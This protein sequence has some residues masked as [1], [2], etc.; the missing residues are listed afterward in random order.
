MAS[1]TILMKLHGRRAPGVPRWAAWTAYTITLVALPSCVWR[2]AAV[3]FNAP[4]LEHDAKTPA[5]PE[6]F[7]GEWWYIIGLS[8]VSEMLAFLAVGLV[9]Q[10]GEVWPRWI[11]GL[12]GRRVPVLAAVIPAGLGSLGLL[13]FPYA[14]VMSAL[15]LKITG[16]PHA[17]VAHGWQVVAFWVAYVPLAAWGPL[18]GI[19][20]VHYYR[21]RR[22]VRPPTAVAAPTPSCRRRVP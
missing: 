2:I 6:T 9:A 17:M 1:R 20:T 15:G 12:R 14:M 16:E 5:A 21:R 4:L 10:W 8:L 18:L 13:V 19:L 11:L 7:D 3:N 22:S